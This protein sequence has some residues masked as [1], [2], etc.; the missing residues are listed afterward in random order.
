[1]KTTNQQLVQS[2][3]NFADWLEKNQISGDEVC[4][5]SID[6]W[7]EWSI[8]LMPDALMAR[9]KEYNV[10]QGESHNHYYG[11]FDGHKVVACGDARYEAARR[12]VAVAEIGGGA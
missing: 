2:V 12:L 9:A 6:G 5:L 11:Y 10:D 4:G 8:Q 1:M 7:G 3:R